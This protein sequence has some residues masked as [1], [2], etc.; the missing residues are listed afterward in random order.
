MG[1]FN[2]KPVSGLAICSL[3]HGALSGC[4]PIL[5]SREPPLEDDLHRLEGLVVDEMNA[6][7][8]GVTVRAAGRVA[9]T[10]AEGR[11]RLDGVETQGDTAPLD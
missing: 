8:P 1:D 7:L 3:A 9:T 10:D 2:S 6:P 4:Q 11:F 5:L